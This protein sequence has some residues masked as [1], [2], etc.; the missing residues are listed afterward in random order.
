MYRQEY[1]YLVFFFDVC[2]LQYWYIEIYGIFIFV[3]M[4]FKKEFKD[5][6]K[7]IVDVELILFSVFYYMEIFWY[8]KVNL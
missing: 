7:C 6:Y 2:F 5:Y 3:L 4:D 8:L 1:N